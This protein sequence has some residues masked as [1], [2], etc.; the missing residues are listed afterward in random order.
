[1]TELWKK[2]NTGKPLIEIASCF[3]HMV[4]LVCRA[5]VILMF[6]HA[7]YIAIQYYFKHLSHHG[8]MFVQNTSKTK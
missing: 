5:S 1:M 8:Q 2:T 4:S 6:Y 7:Y 3:G